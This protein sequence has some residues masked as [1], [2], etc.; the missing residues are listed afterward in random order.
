[1]RVQSNFDAI[2]HAVIDPRNCQFF[3]NN[4]TLVND[5]SNKQIHYR[6][7]AC[8]SVRNMVNRDGDRFFHGFLPVWAVTLF[9]IALMFIII[10]LAGLICHLSGC[11][12][13][14]EESTVDTNVLM[15]KQS[16]LFDDN[17]LQLTTMASSQKSKF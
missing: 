5:S 17:Q 3:S 13:R 16:L 4:E 9:G 10:F 15:A 7:D 1:M 8:P 12:K 11:R 6:L 2:V 14:Q